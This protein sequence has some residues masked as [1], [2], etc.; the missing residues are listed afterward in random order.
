[1]PD[2]HHPMTPVSAIVLSYN[3]PTMLLECVKSLLIQPEITEII[4]I[5][6]GS[7][8]PDME[9]TYAQI[10]SIPTSIHIRILVANPAL[11]YSAAHNW[12]LDEC[13]NELVLL[14][15]ND[16]KLHGHVLVHAVHLMEDYPNI[17]IVGARILN[18][19]MTVN[20]LGLIPKPHT[21]GYE[22][23]GRGLPAMAA[24]PVHIPDVAAV[25]AACVLLRRTHLRFDPTYW[26]ALEDTDL[27]FQYL[28]A[29]FE[30][31]VCSDFVA[32][33]PESTTRATVQEVN[34][35]WA[36]KQAHG[37]HY[38][39]RKW[40]SQWIKD[41]MRFMPY[42]LKIPDDRIRTHV[43]N[44]FSTWGGIALLLI[45]ASW[46][47]IIAEWLFITV[48]TMGLFWLLRSIIRWILGS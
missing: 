38:F 24:Y 16:A 21:I 18:P 9:A 23:I 19:D 32:I 44:L 15:N 41:W 39:K 11:S 30:I 8:H 40:R 34:R 22:H 17:G 31:A 33:H 27:C 5:E 35:E 36:V 48:V 26:F 20:H 46:L 14:I 7:T 42:F 6:N 3:I 37:T 45:I 47:P 29:K 2:S 4:I 1:M 12:G 43:L 13:V 25:T 10:Q 28:Q